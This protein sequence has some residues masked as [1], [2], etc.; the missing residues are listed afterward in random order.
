[1]LLFLLLAFVVVGA[2]AAWLLT[3]LCRSLPRSN[4]DFGGL[5]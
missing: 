3:D 1:M 4:A 2:R 5:L